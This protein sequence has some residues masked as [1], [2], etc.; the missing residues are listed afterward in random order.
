MGAVWDVSRHQS[1]P[2]GP[3]TVKEPLMGSKA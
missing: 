1:R 3:E 2:I